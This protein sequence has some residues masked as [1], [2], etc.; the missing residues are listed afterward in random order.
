VKI[1]LITAGFPQSFEK[2]F[3]N[4]FEY[5]RVRQQLEV[6]DIDVTFLF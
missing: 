6:V 3:T 5:V 4:R 1:I 2:L